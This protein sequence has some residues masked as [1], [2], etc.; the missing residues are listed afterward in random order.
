MAEKWGVTLAAE[1]VAEVRTTAD[2][3]DLVARAISARN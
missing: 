2:V 3:I 1:D